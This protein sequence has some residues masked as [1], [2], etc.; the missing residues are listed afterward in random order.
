[1]SN[2]ALTFFKSAS[3]TTPSRFSNRTDGS[4]PMA[5]VLRE[6]AR[7]APSRLP[8]LLLGPSGCGKELAAR[9]LH[10]LSGRTGPLVPVNGSAISESL[11]ESELFGHVK[12]A[13]TS[14]IQT[15]KGYFEVADRGTIFFDEIAM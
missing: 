7:V 9:E 15:K 8:V 3:G 11:M 12:G 2:A 4:E 10:R 6:L 14:A 1:M 5:S 13:F